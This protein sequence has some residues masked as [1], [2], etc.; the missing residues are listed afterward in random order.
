MKREVLAT[1][2]FPQDS[3]IGTMKQRN[4]S[5]ATESRDGDHTRSEVRLMKKHSNKNGRGYA[6][7]W[8]SGA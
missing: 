2:T 5:Y 3:I 8:W 1:F 7:Q 4:E 6:P